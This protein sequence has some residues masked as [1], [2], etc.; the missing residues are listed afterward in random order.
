MSRRIG[1]TSANHPLRT[2]VAR[3]ATDTQHWLL[4]SV[5]RRPSVSRARIRILL[6]A[7]LVLTNLLIFAGPLHAQSNMVTGNLC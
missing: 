5:I 7:S 4:Q 6:A 2:T 1:N 3:L